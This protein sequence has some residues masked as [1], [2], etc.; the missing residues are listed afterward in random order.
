MSEFDD[1]FKALDNINIE[2]QTEVIKQ[3]EPIRNK[4]VQGLISDKTQTKPKEESKTQTKPKKRITG[5]KDFN[6]NQM[7]NWFIDFLNLNKKNFTL[8]WLRGQK[9]TFECV[10]EIRKNK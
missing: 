3:T 4:N 9:L 10:N 7:I 5:D 2:A 6:K 1:P 8:D